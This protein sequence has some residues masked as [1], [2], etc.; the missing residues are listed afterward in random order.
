MYACMHA[1]M[2]VCRYVGMYVCMYVCMCAYLRTYIYI[3]ACI[4]VFSFKA[5]CR[6]RIFQA[7]GLG[8]RPASGALGGLPE[9][10]RSDVRF[11]E[12][13]PKLEQGLG[14]RFRV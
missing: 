6:L 1:C 13:A 10:R 12:A 5:L 3:Y 4:F 7:V 2:Y 14:F 9:V 11:L 8:P